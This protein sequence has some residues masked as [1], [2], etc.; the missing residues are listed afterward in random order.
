MGRT[1]I[2]GKLKSVASKSS[3]AA[4]Q[5]ALPRGRS[6]TAVHWVEL[7]ELEERNGPSLAP[8][9][10]MAGDVERIY[11]NTLSSKKLSSEKLP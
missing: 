5:P 3:W 2:V 4:A 7:T 10:S 1:R 9:A 6:D 8:V 11:W